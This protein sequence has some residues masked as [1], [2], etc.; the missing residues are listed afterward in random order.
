MRQPVRSGSMLGALTMLVAAC[1]AP[2]EEGPVLLQVPDEF[3]LTI[4]YNPGYQSVLK[5]LKQVKD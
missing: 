5:D 2:F 3:C 4:S 1:E